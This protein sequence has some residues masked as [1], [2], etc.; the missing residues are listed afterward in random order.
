MKK[1]F[2][3]IIAV[4]FC[5][6]L[7]PPGAHSINVNEFKLDNGLKVLIVEEHKSPVATFQIWYRV[8]SRN[9]AI[10][11][12]GLS[13]LLEHM[14]FKGTKKFG[15]KTF[16]QTI[17]RAGG[18]DN[19]FTTY[20]YT[21]YFELISA[22]R[23]NIPITLEAD[24]M[25][26]LVLI[27]EAVLS[28]R[29]VVMEERRLRLEDDPQNVVFEEVMAASFK[30]HPYR[31]PVI[32]WMSDLQALNPE[33]LINHYK[34]YYVPDNAVVIVVGDV[35]TKKTLSMIKESFGNIPKGPEMKESRFKEDEQRG[36]RWLYV[37]KE[38]ELPFV[39]STF[40]VPDISH[41]DSSALEV[42]GNILSG[43]KSSRLYKTL[44]YEKQLTVS[45]SAWYDGM[46]KEPFLFFFD[47]TAAQ[48]KR[49]EDVVRALAEEI[50]KIKKGPPT[51]YEVQK[52]KNQIE[53]D[54]IMRQDSVYNQART[55][56]SFE[57]A[58]GWKLMDKYLEGIR[59]VTPEDVRRVA[60][61]YLMDDRKTT[62]ILVPV[63]EIK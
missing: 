23:I 27:P 45:A 57:M 7:L 14:M 24:R 16:S 8:G 20:E 19:A 38:A 13:H 32:G 54:F 61:E 53:A 62:G 44:V 36:E 25:Q 4:F 55:I 51:E 18:N 31:W 12:T 22:D 10:G 56:G 34:K 60:A 40:K 41:K 28:E 39:L 5:L 52:A 46:M 58:G 33:D 6:F 30:N 43:G 63:R 29:D 42:L 1:L 50:E 49:M 47:A 17:Q 15:P 2:K 35:D 11:K 21:G 3:S 48:G 26:N 37:K 59:K 9:E